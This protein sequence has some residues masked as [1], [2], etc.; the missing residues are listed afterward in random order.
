MRVQQRTWW[1][2]RGS[3]VL[4]VTDLLNVIHQTLAVLILSDQTG[5]QQ[6]CES[7]RVRLKRVGGSVDKSSARSGR[8]NATA[9]KLG[10]YSTHSPRS[11]IHFLAH[12]SK[13][14][15]P[16][17]NSDLYPS[18]QFSAAAMTA[19]EKNSENS[20]FFQSRKKV[21]VRRGQIRRIG[22]LIKIL[23]A[24][25]GQ[26]LLGCECPVSRVIVVQEEDPLGD[27]LAAFFLQNI[28]KLHQQRWVIIRV[29]S[30][31]LW[32]TMRRTPSWSQKIGTRNFPADF[33]T[34]IFLGRSEFA[35][36]PLHWLLLCLRVIV[37]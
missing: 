36:P 12:C 3:Y 6:S 17:K 32:K 25:E 19:S 11:S 31:A 14:C 33:C 37:I 27:L 8:K 21:V 30:L 2:V 10:I 23:E 28:I 22:W 1:P 7:S 35:M 29:H 26:V 24:Q 4:G 34:R 15:K 16:L 5:H 13:L 18:N 9:T 20:I